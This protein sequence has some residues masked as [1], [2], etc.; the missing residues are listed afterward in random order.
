MIYLSGI[1][2][3]VYFLGKH[4]EDFEPRDKEGEF[5]RLFFILLIR[6]VTKIFL[7]IEC[8]KI[9]PLSENF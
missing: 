1:S 8:M 6:T 2:V 4:R 7:F 3:V 5:D 9:L